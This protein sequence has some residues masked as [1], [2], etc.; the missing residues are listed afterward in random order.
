[1]VY[2]PLDQRNDVKMFES[3]HAVKPLAVSLEFWHFDV[4]CVEDES[5]K[6]AVL[7]ESVMCT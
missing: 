3:L 4:I 5:S 7:S 2:N 6:Y 1:M